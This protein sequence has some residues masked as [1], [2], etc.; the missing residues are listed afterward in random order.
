M[1]GSPILSPDA[2]R[3][4]FGTSLR[5]K[6]TVHTD[7]GPPPA[8]AQNFDGLRADSLSWLQT[9][10]GLKLLYVAQRGKQ[11]QAYLDHIPTGETL[12]AIT[13]SSFQRS[14]D[15]R[16]FAFAGIR[17]GKPVV[18]KD[19][20]L[21][22]THDELGAGTFVFSPDS[23]HLGYAARQGTQWFACI[24]GQ[25]GAAAFAGIAAQPLAFSPDSARIAFTAVAPDKTWR[26]IVG[27]DGE[28]QSKA[29]ESFIKGSKP[30]W[31]SN[32]T[33]TTL[34]I[35]KRVALRLEARLP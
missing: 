32:T 6:W 2:K 29:Y 12:D 22:A 35:Q 10:D 18:I 25:P 16:H 4:A 19:G 27:K 34:A 26:L 14:P 21:L 9:D 8:S 24:D 33:L 3:L 13:E 31:R 17:T 20:A 23:Q 1:K 28:W 15:G 5:N 11:W 7:A 30:T